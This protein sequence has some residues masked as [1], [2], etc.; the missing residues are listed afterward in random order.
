MPVSA[1][2]FFVVTFVGRDRPGLVEA[3]AATVKKHGGNWEESR[4]A[5]LAGEFAGIL[6]VS[7]ATGNADLLMAALEG[8]RQEGLELVVRESTETPAVY[9]APV[10]L[11]IFGQDRPGI[12]EE[13]SRALARRGVNVEDLHTETLSAPMTGESL[14]RAT[15]M[16]RLPRGRSVEHLRKDLDALADELTLDLHVDE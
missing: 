15:A 16:L 12:V 9:E 5:R 11:E 10:K 14:F 6:S 3:V 1:Q 13:A 4:M 8:L 7:V 2:S